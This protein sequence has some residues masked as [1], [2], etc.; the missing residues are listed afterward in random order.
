MPIFSENQ[1]PNRERT[2][3]LSSNEEMDEQ[4]KKV[5]EEQ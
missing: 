2:G 5:K 1:Q 3:S 4:Q